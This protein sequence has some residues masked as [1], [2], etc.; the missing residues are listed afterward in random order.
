VP[1]NVPCPAH[2]KKAHR[3]YHVDAC[4]VDGAGNAFHS[5]VTFGVYIRTTDGRCFLCLPETVR[6]EAMR[7]TNY[8]V[9]PKS[10]GDRSHGEH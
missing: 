2:L 5:S 10:T 1:H 3:R 6:V 8:E 4:W 9:K 7:V